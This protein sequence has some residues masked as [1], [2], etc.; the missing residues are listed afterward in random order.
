MI[1]ADHPDDIAVLELLRSFRS[2][3]QW[4]EIVVK[5]EAGRV[6][7]IKATTTTKTTIKE[8]KP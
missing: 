4:G 5:L 7:S 6:S 8:G 3:R 1:P 2:K